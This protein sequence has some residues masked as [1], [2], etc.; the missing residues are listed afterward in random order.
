M[1]VATMTSKG[2]VTIPAE[3]RAKLRLETGSRIVFEE[4]PDGAF[5]MRRQTGD[6][7]TLRGMLKREGQRPI[8]IEE[9][10]EAIAAEAAARF[11]RSR[12]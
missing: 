1:S 8:S 5:V 3:V 4:Q 12:Y 10:D 11:D 7:R 6:I 2:Q 9:M